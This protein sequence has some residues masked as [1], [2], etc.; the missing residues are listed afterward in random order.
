MYK[1]LDKFHMV[2]RRFY[3]SIVLIIFVLGFMSCIKKQ[4]GTVLSKDFNG[5]VWNR[6]DYLEA[7]F[8]V[9]KA[10]MTADLVMNIC[11][12]D[13]YPNIYPYEDDGFFTIAM[14]IAGPDGSRRSREYK[15]RLKDKDGVFKS[16]KV[17]GYYNFELPLISEMSFSENGEYRFK[18]ENKYPKDPLYGIKSLTI[19]CLQIKTK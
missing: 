14:T 13:V 15:F 10:P 18:I 2:K 19:N 12:S 6:F 17:G 11:V 4:D 9:V 16:E 3:T 5:E 7:S 1:L 8:N